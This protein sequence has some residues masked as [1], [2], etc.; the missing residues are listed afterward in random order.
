MSGVTLGAWLTTGGWQQLAFAILTPL[1]IA[2]AW[3]DVREHRIPNK[4]VFPGAVVA[5]LLAHLPGGSVSSAFAGVAVGMAVS[6]PLYWLRAM[7]AGDVKL[8]GMVG[9]FL[10]GADMFAAALV[11]FVVGG[12]LGLVVVARQRAMSQLG[13]NLKQMAYGGLVRTFCGAGPPV[14]SRANSVGVQPYGVAIASGTLL[15]LIVAKGGE[16]FSFGL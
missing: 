2:A 1:L 7:G 10:G 11:I 4:L 13:A 8:L 16:L 3:V 15:Y 5:L 14:A 12:L 9:G 6:L